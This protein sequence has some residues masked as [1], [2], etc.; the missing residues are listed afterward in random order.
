MG[1][2]KVYAT[3]SERLQSFASRQSRQADIQAQTEGALAGAQ[4]SAGKIGGT[5]MMD[6]NT[7]RGAAFNK[8]ARAGHAAAIQ[9]DIRENTSRLE[10]QF[11]NDIEGFNASM[12]KYKEGLVS[13]IDPSMRMYVETDLDQYAGASQTRIANNAFKI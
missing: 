7:I 4:Q 6:E 3:L 2:A 8:A 1:E 13:E 12:A 11:A 9:N 5:Q 10:T